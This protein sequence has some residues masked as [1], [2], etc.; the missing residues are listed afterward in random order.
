MDALTKKH[1]QTLRPMRGSLARIAEHEGISRQTVHAIVKQVNRNT[2]Q[3]RREQ[4]QANRR[5]NNLDIVLRKPLR[6]SLAFLLLPPA[7]SSF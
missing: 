2:A 1:L 4:R 6:T 3:R 7:P 5:A